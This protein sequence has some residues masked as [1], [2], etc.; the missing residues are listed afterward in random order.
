MTTLINSDH[1]AKLLL[2]QV[3]LSKSR[4]ALSRNFP[5][6]RQMY[7]SHYHKV[8]DGIFQKEFSGI[9]SRMTFNRG[10]KCAIAAPRESA[11]STIIME[12]ILYCICQ[13]L[14]N[15]IVVVSN[16]N[17]QAVGFLT[18]VKHELETNEFL[19]RDFPD[20]CEIGRMPGPPRWTQK[21]IVTRNNIKVLAL[22]TGQQI[23]GRRNQESRPSLIALDDIES[24]DSVQNPDSYYKL[25]DWLTKSALK[26]GNSRT[27][28]IYG[29]T[30]HCYGSLL[31]QF[32]SSTAF[33]G[34]NKRVY[35]SIISWSPRSELW[36]TWI[37]IF[38][39]QEGYNGEEGPAAARKFFEANQVTMLEGTDVLWPASKSYYDLMVMREQDGRVSFDS[40]M[41]NEPVNPRD[42]YFNPAEFHYWDDKFKSE[43]ELLATLAGHVTIFG[44]CD[45]SMG[46]QNKRSDYSVIITIARDTN[47]GTMYVLDADVERRDPDKTINDILSHHE[48]R[49]YSKFGFESVQCQEFIATTLQK[50]AAAGRSLYV[51]QI[52][53]SVDKQ[54]RIAALQPMVKDGRV[55]FSRRHHMLHEHMK[56]FPR[57][58]HDDA[59]DCLEMACTTASGNIFSYSGDDGLPR[60]PKPGVTTLP[61]EGLVPYGYY[62][63]GGARLPY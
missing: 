42:C 4:R 39:H 14:E 38:N 12:Y 53:H 46:K 37:R 1:A 19:I 60:G 47:T 35:R 24:D 30:I 55:Q 11:K 15:F 56:Y 36:E 48:R 8:P 61:I 26:A 6:F 41:Q 29:G 31:A 45:P 28:I 34:W 57:G 9:L 22:G 63:P 40:E 49:K 18:D 13:K 27:N 16:T 3:K 52:K 51:W 50:R 17:D 2:A 25:Q 33:P 10:S 23:R 21:E 7:F 59:A 62:G 20:V 58:S 32:T 5:L 44:A 43:E 54:T